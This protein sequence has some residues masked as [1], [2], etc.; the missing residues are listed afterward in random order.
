MPESESRHIRNQNSLL[1]GILL[2]LNISSG[3]MP[4]AAVV[5]VIVRIESLSE[6]SHSRHSSESEY[7][8]NCESCRPS[9]ES[10]SQS[11]SEYVGESQIIRRSHSS[12]RANPKPLSEPPELSRA[13]GMSLTAA[14]RITAPSRTFESEIPAAIRIRR[15][16][17]SSEWNHWSPSRR[18]NRNN[19]GVRISRNGIVPVRARP[20]FDPECRRNRIIRPES[21]CR[22]SRYPN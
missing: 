21:E 1:I 13:V 5:R 22:N 19:I 11:E 3:V 4:S 6:L 15:R 17:E 8:R 10:S 7:H 14:T 20:T 9:S 16:S 2:E 18:R 12:S